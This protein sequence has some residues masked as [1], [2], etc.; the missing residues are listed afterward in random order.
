MIELLL[1]CCL[2]YCIV[3]IWQWMAPALMNESCPPWLAHMISFVLSPVAAFL[4][5][6]LAF[7]GEEPGIVNVLAAVVIAA[8]LTA[9]QRHFTGKRQPQSESAGTKDSADSKPGDLSYRP[10]P[11]T[12]DERKKVH[13]S[14]ARSPEPDWQQPSLQVKEQDSGTQAQAESLTFSL[15][16]TAEIILADDV[17]TQREAELLLSLLDKQDLVSFDPLSRELHQALVASLDDGVFDNREAEEIKVLLSEICDRPVAT[18]EPQVVK[19]PAKKTSAQRKAPAKKV[20]SERIRKAGRALQPGDLLAFMYTDS[21]GDY[22]DREI[23]FRSASKKD[24]VI[25][26]KGICHTRNAMRTFR[27]DRMDRLC[28]LDTG[29]MIDDIERLLG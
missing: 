16:D 20:S 24:S 2:I 27:A 5:L 4:A 13:A 10:K 17:V 21:K 26:L 15:K 3:V 1:V 12:E 28:F 19:K 14:I 8:I 23:N 9:G 11:L 25:Y 22:S 6:A 29:E 7:G 18:S